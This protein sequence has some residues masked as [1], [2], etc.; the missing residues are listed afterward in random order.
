MVAMYLSVFK[1]TKMDIIIRRLYRN[2]SRDNRTPVRKVLEDEVY[3]NWE[4][5]SHKG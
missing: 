1:K 2:D 4:C 5:F 3:K